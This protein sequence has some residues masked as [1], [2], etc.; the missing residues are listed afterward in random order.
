MRS[1]RAGRIVHAYLLCG[2]HGCGK[3]TLARLIA[4]A[5]LCSA[6]PEARPCGECPACKRFL[7]GNHPDVRVVT[8]AGRSIGVDEVRELTEYLSRRPY[9]GGWHVAIIERA[10]AMTASAQNA[11]L[12]TLENPPEDTA[13]FL[14]AETAGALLPTVR[15]R[16]RTVRVTP[17]T[18]EACERALAGHGVAPERARRLAG[19]AHGSVGRALE[20]HADEGFEPLVEQVQRAL[21]TLRGRGSVA[22]AA[23]PLYDARERQD[24][25]LSILEAVGRD[26]MAAQNGVEGV[27]LSAAELAGVQVDG[28]ALMLAVLEA[29]RMLQ[30]NVAWQSALDRLLFAASPGGN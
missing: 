12:K 8:P 18:R 5:L 1:A 26:R 2:E 21:S 10:D 20:L 28:Q 9:E 11:L 14:L 29:R 22:Q 7:S 27:A 30:A 19:F 15:S 24:D 25:V 16:L 3:R 6:Q 13:F 4:Q 23:A 17:L